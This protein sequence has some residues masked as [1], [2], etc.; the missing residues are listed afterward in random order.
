MIDRSLNTE[1]TEVQSIAENLWWVIPGKLAGMRKPAAEDLAPLKAMGIEAIVSVLDDEENLDL[2][3]QAQIPYLWLP[4][5]GGTAP[6][7]AQIQQFRAFVDGYDRG[8]AVHC[9]SGR[10]RTGT[11]LAAYLVTTGMSADQAI[12]KIMQ[13]NPAVELRAAQI[14]FLQDL[15][16]SLS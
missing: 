16:T 13:A 6:S 3:Q 1:N 14:E 11:F 5:I 15:A 7:L 2:Y 12:E 9:T 4:V 10:R 8:V